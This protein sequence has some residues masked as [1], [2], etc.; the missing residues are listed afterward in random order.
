MSG[1]D[2]KSHF[3]AVERPLYVLRNGLRPSNISDKPKVGNLLRRDFMYQT[4]QSIS[5]HPIAD[6]LVQTECDSRLSQPFPS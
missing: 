6:L 3:G 4:A 5:A 2:M 1:R